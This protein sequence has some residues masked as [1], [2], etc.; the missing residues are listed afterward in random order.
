MTGATLLLRQIHPNLVQ[1]GFA[2]SLAFRPNDSDQGLMSTYDGDLIT[3][4]PPQEW[5]TPS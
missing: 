5:W 3:A 4:E 1:D 2:S